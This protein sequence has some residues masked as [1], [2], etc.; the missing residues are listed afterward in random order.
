MFVWWSV[1]MSYL[2]DTISKLYFLLLSRFGLFQTYE[3][4]RRLVRIRSLYNNLFSHYFY[5]LTFHEKCSF[6]NNKLKVLATCKNL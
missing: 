4:D 3:V 6:E 5:I 1:V 2:C